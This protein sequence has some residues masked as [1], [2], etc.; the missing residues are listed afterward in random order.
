M[1]SSETSD[2]QPVIIEIID[3][4]SDSATPKRKRVQTKWPV[5][6]ENISKYLIPSDANGNEVNTRDKR[7]ETAFKPAK[8]NRSN[9]VNRSVPQI[10]IRSPYVD[11]NDDDDDNVFDDCSSGSSVEPLIFA[12]D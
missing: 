5:G 10:R 8:N 7:I 6:M 1:Q 2:D 9:N 4:D 11:E 3:S 12:A